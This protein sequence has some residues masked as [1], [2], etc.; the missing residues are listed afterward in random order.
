MK[1][2]EFKVGDYV[3][4]SNTNEH[5]GD[6]KGQKGWIVEFFPT[7]ARVKFLQYPSA[8]FMRGDLT[9]VTTN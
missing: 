6:Y 5:L 1:P 3:Q 7:T 9:H 8:W 2:V 4:V